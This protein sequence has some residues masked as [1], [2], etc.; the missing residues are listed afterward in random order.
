MIECYKMKFKKH[1]SK[2]SDAELPAEKEDFRKTFQWRIFRI[3]AEFV[4]GFNF[5]ADFKKSVTVFGSTSLEEDNDHYKAARKFGKLMAKEGYMVVTGGGPGIMEAAN[6]GAYEAGGESV[7]INIRLVGGERANPYLKKSI[8][9]YYFFVRKVMLSFSASGYVF[10]PGGFG[11]LD[12]FF[13]IVTLIQTKRLPKDVIVVAVGKDY[14][15]SLF[16]WIK[17]NLAEK[18]K[19]ISKQALNI[20]KLVDTPEEAVELIKQAK[21]N[22]KFDSAE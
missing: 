12:E 19:T 8:G 14:W 4:E 5:V 11:T 16:D 21:H 20:L 9:F 15:E 1:I 10:F 17:S 7:G 22:R 13:E 2:L 18:H 6:R 3:M